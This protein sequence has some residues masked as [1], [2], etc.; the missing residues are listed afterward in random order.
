VYTLEHVASGKG[1]KRKRSTSISRL[2]R[3]SAGSSKRGKRKRKSRGKRGDWLRKRILPYAKKVS[4][5]WTRVSDGTNAVVSETRRQICSREG[6]VQHVPREGPPR[7]TLMNFMGLLIFQSLGITLKALKGRDSKA[8]E[9]E[10]QCQSGDGRRRG[11]RSCRRRS[12]GQ[13]V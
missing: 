1:L 7:K 5:K 11:A 6:R 4:G 9:G 13:G 3:S 2:P 10:G 12:F 8:R